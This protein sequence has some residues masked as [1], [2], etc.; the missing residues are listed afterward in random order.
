MTREKTSKNVLLS[1]RLGA[2]SLRRDNS[3]KRR[4]PMNMCVAPEFVPVFRRFACQRGFSTSRM[5][6]IAGLLLIQKLAPEAID[7]L[8]A[9]APDIFSDIDLTQFGGAA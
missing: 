6:E 9:S 2:R 1:R 4:A 5:M 8:R 7:A 3:R